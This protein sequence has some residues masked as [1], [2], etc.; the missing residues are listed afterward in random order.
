MARKN[1]EQALENIR[2]LNSEMLGLALNMCA[3]VRD[4]TAR[5]EHQTIMDIIAI[6]DSIIV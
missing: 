3:S 2:T 5:D 1:D 4:G 6:H